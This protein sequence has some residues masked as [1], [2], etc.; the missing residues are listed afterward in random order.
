MC[1]M[2]AYVGKPVTLHRA[3]LEPRH[4]LEVQSYQPGEMLSGTVN[5]DGFGCGWYNHEITSEPGVYVGLSTL[6]SD[7]SFQSISRIVDSGLIFSAVRGATAPSPVD[8]QSVQPFQRDRYLFMHNGKIGDFHEKVKRQLYDLLVDD[9][10]ADLKSASDSAVM[11]ALLYNKLRQHYSSL[12]NMER[13]LTELLGLITKLSGEAGVPCQLNIG[14]TDGNEIVFSRY[15]NEDESNSLYYLQDGEAFPDA[16]VVAS[17]RLDD[18]PNWK[19][20]PHNHLFSIN[21]QRDVRLD[22]VSIESNLS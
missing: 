6:W 20:V 11:F 14:L 17:E 15:S 8:L 21:T 7:Y 3:V 4:S 19:P 2:L 1:R 18:D 16:V 13:Y 12:G 5:V 10:F 9:L 22:P